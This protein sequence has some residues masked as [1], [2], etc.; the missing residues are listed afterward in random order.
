M[1]PLEGLDHRLLVPGEAR[2]QR[3]ALVVVGVE[4]P[5]ELAREKAS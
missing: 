3:Q 4:R 5:S 2:R 1:H